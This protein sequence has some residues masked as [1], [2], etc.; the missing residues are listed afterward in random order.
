MP[1]CGSQIILCNLPIR[2]DT[3]K[4]CSH[5]CKYCFVTR[6]SDITKIDKKES[7][8]SL[9]KFIQ[10]NRSKE[11]SWADW[12][13]PLHWG[14]TSDPF[15][16]IELKYRYS[17]NALKVFAETKYPFVVST[18]GKVIAQQ[19]Y[20]E[21]L[22]ETNSVIQVSLVSRSYDNLEPGAPSFDERVRIIK[23]LVKETN[24][25]LIVRVQPYIKDIKKDLL[26]NLKIFSDI[27]VYGITIEGIK[28]FKKTKG[29]IK[30][31]ADFCYPTEVLK[32]DF[33]EIREKCHNLGLKFYSAENRLRYMGDDLT[34]CGIDGLKDFKPNK[35]NLNYYVY[36]REE[37][38]YSEQMKQP[39]SGGPFRT[40]KQETSLGSF[41][42]N[43]SYENNFEAAIKDKNMLKIMGIE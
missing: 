41:L 17:L 34:C 38:K 8:T 42:E 16:P 9:L 30:V 3:Y 4:G 13:I 27:G 35:T 6:K 40:M 25:R 19:E 37:F 22:K 26:E 36:K 1:E 5:G 24:K 14:G 29:F 11:T 21:L 33:T 28:L 32:K 7:H 2:F 43:N 20:V 23:K 31:G 10:G 15:Q 39:K 12:N 18:K